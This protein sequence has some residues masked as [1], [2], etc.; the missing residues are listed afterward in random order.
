[1][2]IE[3]KFARDARLIARSIKDLYPEPFTWETGD[4]VSGIGH[5]VTALEN[6][7]KAKLKS[8]AKRI[9]D[10]TGKIKDSH[11]CQELGQLQR[12]IESILDPRKKSRY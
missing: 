3:K 5:V 11:V 4:I 8:A 9:G 10:L 1:M 12:E 2:F 7:S 6:P